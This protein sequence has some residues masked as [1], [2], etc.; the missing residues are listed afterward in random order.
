MNLKKRSKS[1]KSV[2]IPKAEKRSKSKNKMIQSQNL[3]R[4]KKGS[5]KRDNP[6]KVKSQQ[7]NAD[8][9]ASKFDM[10]QSESSMPK[11][12]LENHH[13][14]QPYQEDFTSS[15]NTLQ[16]MNL[17][18]NHHSLGY[19]MRTK[20]NIFIEDAP[21][22]EVNTESLPSQNNLTVP[23]EQV[24]ILSMDYYKNNPAVLS[25]EL[26]KSKT[27]RVSKRSRNGK[28]KSKSKSSVRA[29]STR[30]N[31]KAEKVTLTNLNTHN[32]YFSKSQNSRE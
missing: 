22:F 29:M 17:A 4:D 27:S 25:P 3:P 31:L 8:I 24:Q 21:Q 9:R 26:S 18:L 11:D 13:P 12:T 23:S 10:L 16:V 14:N 30:G 28:S 6:L 19:S 20:D 32:S 5:K 1:K 2:D 15:Q 7:F